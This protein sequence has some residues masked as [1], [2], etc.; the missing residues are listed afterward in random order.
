MERTLGAKS[1]KAETNPW[2]RSTRASTC[3]PDDEPA[4]ACSLALPPSAN[5]RDKP[6]LAY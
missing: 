1:S 2:R 5:G 3:A 6:R 4:G